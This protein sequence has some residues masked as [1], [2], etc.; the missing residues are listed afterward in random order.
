MGPKIPAI[1]PMVLPVTVGDATVERIV[2]FYARIN[3]QNVNQ[4][5]GAIYAGKVGER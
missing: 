4:I 1:A 2:N 3:T 5:N